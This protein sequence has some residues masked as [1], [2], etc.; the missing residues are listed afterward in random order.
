[1]K[2][3][4]RGIA[5]PCLLDRRT[6]LAGIA[7]IAS[8][9]PAAAEGDSPVAHG[10]LAQN[11]LALAF[12]SAPPDLPYVTLV[13]PNGE[14]DL[15]DLLNGRTVLMPLWAEWCAPCL[16]EI[17]DFARLQTKYGNSK[18]AVI[19]ILTG[20]QK[21]MTPQVIGELFTFL[22]A[23]IFEPLIEKHLGGKLMQTMARR[24]RE[25]YIPCNLLI[26]PDGRVVGREIGAQRD[27]QQNQMLAAD[28]KQIRGE[29]PQ[30]A[31][32][33][34]GDVLSLWGKA[35]GEEFAAAMADGFLAQS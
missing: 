17:P 19:P 26:G 7:A 13:G 11:P 33:E 28:P 31:R 4:E 15:A 25:M 14:H 32:A 24:G 8:V 6:V 9:S 20:T 30:I 35:P 23:G 1:M 18:F 16:S 5:A 21:Q 12:E 3:I 22:H 27:D 29:N 10:V 34:A 2:S